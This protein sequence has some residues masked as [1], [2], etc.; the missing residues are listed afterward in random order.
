MCDI[1]STH[2]SDGRMKRASSLGIAAM[3]LLQLGIVII[4]KARLRSYRE[5]SSIFWDNTVQW[6]AA[7]SSLYLFT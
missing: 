3:L 2:W 6:H 7:D 5:A 1:G 4:I